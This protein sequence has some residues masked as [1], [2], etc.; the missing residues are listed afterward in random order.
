MTESSPSFL[1]RIAIACGSFFAILG[2]PELAAQFA[3]LRARGPVAPPPPA[4]AAPP[5][6]EATPDAALQL[7]GML[8]RDARLIDFVEE[9][10]NAYSDADIGA[11]AR[12]VHEGCRKTLREHFGIQPI[13]SESEGSRITLAPGFDAAANR[14]TGKVVGAP[15]FTGTLSHRGWRVVDVRLPRLSGGHDA[16]IVAQAEVEL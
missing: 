7:L 2:S 8:Q 15:P 13:R 16:A 4:P 10:I 12:L 6:R 9:D 3:A 14:I 11:A 1:R 5:L